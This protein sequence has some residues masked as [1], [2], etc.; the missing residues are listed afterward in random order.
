MTCL[1]S[2]RMTLAADL[3]LEN[4]A[5]V[6]AVARKVGDDN[7]FTFSTAFK[8]VHGSSPRAYRELASVDHSPSSRS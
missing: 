6:G 4:G 7:P 5:M 1:T 2:W 3:L 8:R